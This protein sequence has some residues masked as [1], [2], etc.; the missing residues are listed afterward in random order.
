MSQGKVNC[1]AIERQLTW[2]MYPID[3]ARKT[4]TSYMVS[5]IVLS[6][7]SGVLSAGFGGVIDG[8][9]VGTLPLL[10]GTLSL[11]DTLSAA[12]FMCLFVR[13]FFSRLFFFK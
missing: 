3:M 11:F 2:K 13:C 9:G 8:A 7:P 12:I 5:M 6:R 10:S 1:N 4:T